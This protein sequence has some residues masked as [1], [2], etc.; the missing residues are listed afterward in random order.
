[1]DVDLDRCC[2]TADCSACDGAQVGTWENPVRLDPLPLPMSPPRPNLFAP[3]HPQAREHRGW[4]EGAG[5]P[6]PWATIVTALP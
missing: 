6:R 1:M 3:E 2:R 5:A 4:R